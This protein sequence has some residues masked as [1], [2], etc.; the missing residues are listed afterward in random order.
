VP[1]HPYEWRTKLRQ[2]LPWFL[3]NLGVAAKGDDCEAVGA[4]HHSYNVDGTQSACYHCRVVRSG[5][6]WEPSNQ[7]TAEAH[8]RLATL[9]ESIADGTTGIEQG[10]VDFQS[11]EAP[12]GDRAFDDAFHFMKHYEAD[13]DIRERDSQFADSQ[14]AGLRSIAARLRNR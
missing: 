12:A 1:R 5:R 2:R 14:V 9:L 6:L 4:E 11:I 10:L 3:I 8:V 7:H 13:A